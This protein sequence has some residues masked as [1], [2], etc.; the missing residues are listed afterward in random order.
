M[1]IPPNR[2]LIYLDKRSDDK[3]LGQ[4]TGLGKAIKIEGKRSTCGS[5][6]LNRQ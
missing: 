2:K 6:G 3:S 4:L 5:T 1:A